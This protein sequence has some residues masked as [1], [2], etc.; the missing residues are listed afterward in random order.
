[1]NLRQ[2][3]VDA[4]DLPRCYGHELGLGRLRSAIE[5]IIFFTDFDGETGDVSLPIL[6]R[7]FALKMSKVDSYER[8]VAGRSRATETST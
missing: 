6:A 1:M 4:Q 5:I 2:G 8:R 3:R 7:D